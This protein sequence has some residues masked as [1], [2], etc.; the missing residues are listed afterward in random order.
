MLES[1]ELS[2]QPFS[3]R[4]IGTEAEPE[5]VLI[6]NGYLAVNGSVNISQLQS[7]ELQNGTALTVGQGS[8]ELSTGS[9]EFGQMAVLV[10]MTRVRG[11]VPVWVLSP[12]W[13]R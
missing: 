9:D 3:V 8:I 10:S 1:P 11:P 2:E 4:N 12:V 6:F 5:Y 13:V 7:G